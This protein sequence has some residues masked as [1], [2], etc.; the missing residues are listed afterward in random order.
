MKYLIDEETLSRLLYSKY[1]LSALRRQWITLSEELQ[2]INYWED[3]NECTIAEKVKED[4]KKFKQ[5]KEK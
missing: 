1:V 5:V 2:C 3:K 4:L